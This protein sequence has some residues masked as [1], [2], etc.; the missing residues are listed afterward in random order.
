MIRLAMLA[1]LALGVSAT[2]G[3][4]KPDESKSQP[5]KAEKP[6]PDDG[7]GEGTKLAGT[8]VHTTRDAKGKLHAKKNPVELWVSKRSGKEFT[9]V[10]PNAYEVEGTIQ[11]G[12]VKFKVTK[13][14]ADMFK[15]QVGVK[16]FVGRYSYNREKGLGTLK[17]TSTWKTEAYAGEW[18]LKTKKN[19]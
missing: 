6:A 9:A 1:V 2:A 8:L 7:F 18:D 16:T 17:G 10:V 12:V 5:A 14:L 15:P 13:A 19:D 3:A 11:G 4:P